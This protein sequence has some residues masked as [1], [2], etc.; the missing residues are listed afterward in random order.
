MTFGSSN[1]CKT[2][3]LGNLLVYHDT[4]GIA[5][6]LHYHLLVATSPTL[7]LAQSAPS[8]QPFFPASVSSPPQA[9][10]RESSPHAKNNPLYISTA[11]YAGD[12]VDEANG[13]DN[14]HFHDPKCW[15]GLVS[16]DPDPGAGPGFLMQMFEIQ[17]ASHH[18]QHQR[19]QRQTKMGV[20]LA[21]C[22]PLSESDERW[23]YH[24]C[25]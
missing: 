23:A 18:A 22:A 25:L 15:S 14:P 19:H 5:S 9:R 3:M 17:S 24:P 1:E 21:L 2:H 11:L 10:P 6:G 7:Q 12:A 8:H 20:I 4:Q 13:K 16:S